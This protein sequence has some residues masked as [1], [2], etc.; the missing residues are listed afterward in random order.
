MFVAALVL[1]ILKL[2]VI[3]AMSWWIVAIPLM[4]IAGFWAF[5]F[6]LIGIAAVIAFA[7]LD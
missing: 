5:S 4:V 7:R 1:L 6:L 2:T 3:P